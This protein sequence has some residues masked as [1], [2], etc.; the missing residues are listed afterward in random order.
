MLLVLVLLV[1]GGNCW[2]SAGGSIQGYYS[3]DEINSYLE[4]LPAESNSAK[5]VSIG[6]SYLGKS[7]PALVLENTGAPK[8]MIVGTHHA[9]ELISTTQ[10][11]FLI[12]RFLENDDPRIGEIRKN[13]EIWFI[14][15]LNIDGYSYICDKYEATHR[16]SSIRKN[17][18]DTDCSNEVSIGVDLNRNYDDH[19]GILTDSENSPCREAYIGLSPFSEPE[20]QAI[21]DLLTKN[22]TVGLSYHSYGDLYIHPYSYE[23]KFNSDLLRPG[24]YENYLRLKERICFTCEMGNAHQLVQYS[25]SGNFIDY[26]YSQGV[27]SLVVEMGHAFAPPANLIQSI[28]DEHLEPALFLMELASSYFSVFASVEA[29]SSRITVCF[30]NIGLTEGSLTLF[31]E[32][33]DASLLKS[34]NSSHELSQNRTFTIT[35]PRYRTFTLTLTVPIANPQYE[36]TCQTA[37][38][39][40]PILELSSPTSR[41]LKLFSIEKQLWVGF[42]GLVLIGVLALGI[43]Y[44]RRKQQDFA[45]L[46]HSVDMEPSY[47]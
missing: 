45:S 24:D 5:L 11:L 13:T 8:I 26:S 1:S 36:L 19:W 7:I 28:L 46:R 37:K 33:E 44:S 6:N 17:R 27:F 41:S 47:T 39:M 25:V 10:V 3:L 40:S 20:T 22:F 38:C 18:K 43:L 35:L 2:D 31:I 29:E 16:I 12:S 9:R 34:L 4:S 14:P 15:V 32:S 23:D 21:R 42:G 30:T